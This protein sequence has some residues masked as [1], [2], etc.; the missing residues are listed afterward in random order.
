MQPNYE[1]YA[2]CFNMMCGKLLGSG[3]SRKVFECKLRPELVV[4]V[5]EGDY[6]EFANVKEMLYWGEAPDDLKQW[7]APC[8]F[9]SPNGRILLQQRVSPLPLDYV[10]PEKMPRSLTDFKPENFGLFQG[11]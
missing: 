8:E 1:V 5:E 4:K 10:M 6:P 7:L 11:G 9:L 3:V 2:D